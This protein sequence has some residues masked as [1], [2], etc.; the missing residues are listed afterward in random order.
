MRNKVK[1]SIRTARANYY[2][3]RF[4]EHQGDVTN[5]WKILKEI[6]NKDNSKSN[7]ID[8]VI[9]NGETISDNQRLPETFNEHFISIGEELARDIPASSNNVDSYLR[10]L[11]KIE[12]Q[13]KFKCIRPE[14]VWD[15][16]N[17]LKSGKASGM[18]MISN[19]ILKISKDIISNS[20]S[21]IFNEL[22]SQ[23]IFPDDFKVV[24]VTPIHKG[25]ER[26]DADNYRP[27]LS[28]CIRKTYLY[29]QLYDYLMQNNIL[30]DKQWGFRSLHSTALALVDCTKDW[31]INIV[32][33]NS[34]FAVFLDIK[35]AFDTV[36]HEILLQ[37]LKFYGIMSNE[38]SFFKSCLTN[39]SQLEDLSD[40][41]VGFF[42][43]FHRALSLV[44]CCLLSI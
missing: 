1:Y 39:T 29:A 11:R 4:E 26:D 3:N 18:H 2:S 32:K 42:Q 31:L 35:K 41:L 37:K 25:S 40:R 33:G 20:L 36:D 10:K 14:D 43:V 13:F 16:L 24:R 5:T 9:Y 27:I 21:D 8:C 23:Q 38:L 12:S 19:S 34:N 44:R 28:T 6:I 7:D 17:K 15:I 30:G 22:L